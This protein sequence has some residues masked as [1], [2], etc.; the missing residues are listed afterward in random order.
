MKFYKNWFFFRSNSTRTCLCA[1]G[2][3]LQLDER[4]C[5]KPLQYLLFSQ[6][7]SNNTECGLYRVPSSL[8]QLLNVERIHFFNDE[9]NYK[10]YPTATAVDVVG[11]Y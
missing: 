8:K 9:F 11:F 3:E 2:F 1:S 10:P 5:K 7:T 4:S 6:A